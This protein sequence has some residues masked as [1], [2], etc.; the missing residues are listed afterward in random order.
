M[1]VSTSIQIETYIVPGRIIQSL[2]YVPGSKTIRITYLN[3]EVRV[4]HLST[5][6]TPQELD[7][8]LDRLLT[9]IQVIQEYGCY[10]QT[11]SACDL[12]FTQT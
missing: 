6:Y 1:S 7:A 11:A 10:P 12:G 4:L 5:E 9:E 3:N 8:L 2:Y